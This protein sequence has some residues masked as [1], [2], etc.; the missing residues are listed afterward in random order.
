MTVVPFK[1][2]HYSMILE[3]L[4]DRETPWLGTVSYQTLSKIGYIAL[5][6][7]Q[8]IAAGFLRRIEGG[9]GYL[10]T[11]VSN[12]FFGSKMRHEGITAIVDLL[13]EEAKSL[14]LRGI[15]GSTNDPGI[16][17]RAKEKGFHIVEQT[18]LAKY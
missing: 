7:N 3:M 8:P 1:H 2:K 11:F 12:P 4:K 16:V 15:I 17:K 14:E 5:L 13:L 9:Y 6:G 10:D 18:L